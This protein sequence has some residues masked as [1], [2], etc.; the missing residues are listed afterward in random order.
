MNCRPND[1]AMIVRGYP[2]DNIGKIITVTKL[3]ADFSFPTWEYT[4]AWLRAPFGG[5]CYMIDDECL[6]P[7]RDQDGED[8]SLTWAGKPNSIESPQKVTT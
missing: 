4:G 2:A 8:Q 7:I 3:C 1:L 5:K 6:K